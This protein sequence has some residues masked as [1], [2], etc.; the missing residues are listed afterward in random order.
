V[1]KEEIRERLKKDTLTLLDE[2][3]DNLVQIVI[4]TQSDTIEK[5][6]EEVHIMIGHIFHIDGKGSETYL[7]KNEILS[8]LDN[9]TNT[10]EGE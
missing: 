4:E 10:K 6:R 1:N 5:V 2:E 8:L 7:S 9:L 3:L